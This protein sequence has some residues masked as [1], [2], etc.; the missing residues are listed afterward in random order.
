MKKL[1]YVLLLMISISSYSQNLGNPAVIGQSSRNQKVGKGFQIEDTLLAKG[2]VRFSVVSVGSTKDT[3]VTVV[4]TAGYISKVGKSTFLTAIAKD[5]LGVSY[6]SDSIRLYIKG[7]TDTIVFGYAARG[8]DY[9]SDTL[10]WYEG[11]TRYAEYI[12]GG[13][14]V[15]SL[16]GL[17]AAT[18][19]N[20][21]N[22][23]NF[24][25][26]WQWNTHVSGSA[27]KLSSALNT[28]HTPVTGSAVLDVS[29]S[30]GYIPS[31][32]GVNYAAKFVNSY[33]ATGGSNIAIAGYFESGDP[34]GTLN[35]AV[36]SKGNIRIAPSSGR[37]YFGNYAKIYGGDGE[38]RFS[39]ST[40]HTSDNGSYFYGMGAGY[41]MAVI[42][43]LSSQPY[44][45]WQT[46]YVYR[47]HSTSRQIIAFGVDGD[48]RTT[49]GV[50]TS[51]GWIERSADKL[52]FAAQAGLSSNSAIT[53]NY[54]LTLYGTNN[55]VGI[56]T[57]SPVISAALDITSTTKG[58][59]PPR[60]TATQASAISTPAQGL[61]LFVTDTD[62]TFTSVGW[63]GYNGSTWEKLNN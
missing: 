44:Y 56:G 49:S 57:T 53:P 54:L 27:L 32:S 29:L 11:G 14:G 39:P 25:Q 3:F 51:Y 43:N 10:S 60:M 41:Y 23:G 46:S 19:T 4:D 24:Q 13:G 38:L 47:D 30:N 48:L 16:S 36:Y 20:I 17:T 33:N 21:I 12:G 50:G 1:I 62:G 8:L 9:A 2:K 15:A 59:L 18:A 26:E 22:N 40:S 58:F 37:L 28:A 31:F 35:S 45:N 6:R 42:R 7:S 55:N 63:W 52:M 61:L 34:S 5:N